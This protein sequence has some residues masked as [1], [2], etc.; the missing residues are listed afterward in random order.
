MKTLFLLTA[1]VLLTNC[2]PVPQATPPTVVA[3]QPI[4]FKAYNPT[5]TEN[6]HS[7]LSRTGKAACCLNNQE[8]ALTDDETQELLA[9]L[10][11][12]RSSTP[13][14]APEDCFYLNLQATDGTWLMSLPVQFTPEGIVLLYLKLQDNNA[15]APL[16]GWW[17]SV[18]SRLGI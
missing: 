8:Y 17:K 6:L 4:G 10:C 14:C 3:P 11:G 7:A 13:L 15:G 16:Q 18:S 2:S 9:L 1:S 12:A 5:A